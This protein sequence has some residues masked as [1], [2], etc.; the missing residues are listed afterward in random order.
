MPRA[1][2]FR[3]RI[4]QLAGLG[5]IFSNRALAN[6]LAYWVKVKPAKQTVK[7]YGKEKPLQIGMVLEADILHE[8]KKLD[9][10]VLEPLYSISGKRH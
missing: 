7:A 4:R 1:E 6:E 10:W 8:R 9:E 2:S 3:W 5:L